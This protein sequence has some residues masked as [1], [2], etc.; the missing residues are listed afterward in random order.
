M[1]G[2]RKSV[3]VQTSQYSDRLSEITG[4][5]LRYPTCTHRRVLHL[6]KQ[7]YIIHIYKTLNKFFLN[8]EVKFN[9]YKLIYASTYDPSSRIFKYVSDILH[10][11]CQRIVKLILLKLPTERTN[12]RISV[13]QQTTGGK[14][15]RTFASKTSRRSQRQREQLY[16]AH[17]TINTS[18]SK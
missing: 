9:Y 1:Q 7:I 18:D 15:H 3:S 2:R 8:T 17:H 11:L 10:N 5:L 16:L 14:A 12:R 6:G 4:E 13:R